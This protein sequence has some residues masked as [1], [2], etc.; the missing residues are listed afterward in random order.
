MFPSMAGGYPAE[1][2]EAIKKAEQMNADFYVPGHG[3]VDDPATMKAEL[4]TFRHAIE[5]VR[6]EAARLKA[7]GVPAEEAVAKADLGEFADWSIHEQ[8]APTAFRRAYAELDG[9]LK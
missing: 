6:S 1:W 8:M 3:F 5:R 9:A 4:T 2:V 7:A